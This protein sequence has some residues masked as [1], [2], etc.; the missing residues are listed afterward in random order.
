MF[1]VIP[2]KKSL[3]FIFIV[4]ACLS[5][6]CRSEEDENPDITASEDIYINEIIATGGDWLELYNKNPTAVDLSGYKIYDDPAS[7]YILPPGTSIS[8]SGYA[9]LFCDD[10]NTGLHTNF[11]LTSAGETVWL[12]NKAGDVIDKVIF[13]ALLNKQS[14]ARFPD[15][16]T[17]FAITGNATQGSTNGNTSAPSIV[18]VTRIPLVPALDQNVSVQAE[19]G[20]TT[21]VASVT[22][23]YR[24]NNTTFSSV[25][26]TPAGN[27]YAAAISAM[28][29]TGIVEYYIE[30]KNGTGETTT[31][32]ATAPLKF[33]DYILNTDALP[34]LVINEFMSQNVACCADNSSGTAEFDDWIEIYNNG[35]APVNIADFY[36]SDDTSNPFKSKIPATN[37]EATTIQPGGY[38]VIWADEQ[39]DQGELHVGFRLLLEGESI[40]LYYKDGRKIDE[41]TFGAQTTDKS[42]GRLPTGTG[43]IQMLPSPSIGTTN[44]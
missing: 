18:S 24:F 15:G 8:G 9:V 33:H 39:Q 17:T 34:L 20:S 32:P 35:S 41:V 12:E 29:A 31:H 26:M 16:S 10:G 4:F 22:L 11:K 44:N 1:H 30:A 38:L 3:F 25:T 5:S 40:G 42:M 27:V 21:G 6:S 23:Y 37:A 7:K 19:L 14:Y 2:A 43:S 13:P 36:F 28:N